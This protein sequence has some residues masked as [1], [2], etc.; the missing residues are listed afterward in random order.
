MYKTPVA[1]VNTLSAT[2]GLSIPTINKNL[3]I[4][5]ADKIIVELTGNRRNRSFALY[6]YINVF[7]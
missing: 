7:A 3:K 6:K 4:L 1:S 2:T 5:L